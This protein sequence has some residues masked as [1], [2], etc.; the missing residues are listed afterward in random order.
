MPSGEDEAAQ[1][2]LGSAPDN[3]VIGAT[4]A[5]DDEDDE[6]MGLNFF[7]QPEPCFYARGHSGASPAA[8]VAGAVESFGGGGASDATEPLR[9]PVRDDGAEAVLTQPEIETQVGGGGEGDAEHAA[10][11]GSIARRA[12]HAS[13]LRSCRRSERRR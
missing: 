11:V 1:T 7:S 13:L 5:E 4:Q 3:G 10:Q 9:E 2:A 8:P 6:G 12:A